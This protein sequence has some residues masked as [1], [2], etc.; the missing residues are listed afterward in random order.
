M[1]TRTFLASLD[2][3][4]EEIRTAELVASEMGSRIPFTTAPV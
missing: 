2:A 1:Q 4:M 3:D